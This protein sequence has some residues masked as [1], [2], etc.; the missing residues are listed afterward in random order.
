MRRFWIR[1][2]PAVTMVERCGAPAP[3]CVA[4]LIAIALFAF[5]AVRRAGA[6][7]DVPLSVRRATTREG[8]VLRAVA[9]VALCRALDCARTISTALE[10]APSSRWRI[11]AEGAAGRSV[12]QPASALSTDVRIDLSYGDAQRQVWIG[13]GGGTAHGIDASASGLNRWREY[14]AAL[15]WRSMSVAIDV[16][17]GSQPFVG[18]RAPTY[19]QHIIQSFDTLTGATRVDTV[20]QR[21]TA[22]PASERIRWTSTALRLGWRSDQWRLGTVI[23]RASTDA[24]RP[25]VWSTTEAERR[26]GRSVGIVASLGT[27]PGSIGA[28]AASAPRARWM[29]GLGLTAATGR[30]THDTPAPASSAPTTSES[31]TAI[32]LPTGRYR[33]EVLLSNAA[34]VDLASDLTGWRS[35]AMRRDSDGR[36]SVELPATSGVHHASLRID[37]GPWTAPPGSLAEDDGFGGSAGVLMI[38]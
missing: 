31:F 7:V 29:L 30:R 10:L 25:V 33:I 21:S 15:R 11:M 34:H 22:S 24:G 9:D 2:G 36:W 19:E 14:G 4:A 18:E 37:G 1:R 12:M 35:V 27:Y 8:D 16:G 23:G 17:T 32:R 6:Q 38:P 13:R 20:M 28:I 26:I 5:G 3:R